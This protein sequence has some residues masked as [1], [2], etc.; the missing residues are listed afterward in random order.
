MKFDAYAAVTETILKQLEAGA[1]PWV[2]PWASVPGQGI[3]CNATNNRPYSGGN[4][5]LLFIA[6]TLNGFK[7]SRWLTLRQANAAG[8][9]VKE[10]SKGT[11]ICF[12]NAA[13]GFN[14]KNEEKAYTFL[15]GF[16]V[17]NVEQCEGLPESITN[18]APKHAKT[19]KERD[20]LAEA[21]IV[22][23]GAKLTTGGEAYWRPGADEIVMPS[24]EAFKGADHYYATL[25][26][27]LGH[28]TGHKT[29]LDRNMA[30]RFGDRGYAA[31][32][33]VAEMTSAFLCAEFG[34]DGDLRHAGYIAN[35]I[36]LLKADK[37][38]FFSAASKAQKAAD[39]LR[40]LALADE[41]REAA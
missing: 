3:P 23:T 30:G 40:D 37:R 14:D 20:E 29:R 25:F 10:G 32:E 12:V 36:D 39:F 38:A 31:E 11:M 28:W 1:A 4:V 21:F 26:H 13:R 16:T 24:F 18:P 17:F 8:G 9:M 7:S 15:K 34:M 6:Q 19:P 2:K 41:G 35:W 5:F 22:S 27:E 33:L